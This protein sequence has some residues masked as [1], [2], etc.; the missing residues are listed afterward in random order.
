MQLGPEM[1]SVVAI[2]L[3]VFG[4]V[5]CFFG[6]KVF[7]LVLGVL[8][9]LLGSALAA[10]LAGVFVQ[11]AGAASVVGLLGGVIGSWLVFRFYRFGLFILGAVAGALLGGTV[12][13]AIGVYG[14]DSLIVVGAVALLGGI[15]TVVLQ[16]LMII[17]STAFSGAWNM[18]A[19]AAF[20]LFGITPLALTQNPLMLVGIKLFA[21]IGAWLVLGLIG[22]NYQYRGRRRRGAAGGSPPA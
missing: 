10:S 22:L 13:M 8:G 9:F 6:Y 5:S 1:K 15:L 11:S 19:G 18:V 21:V 14:N 3:I 20:L 16:K 4:A 12:A 7:R 17:T 2:G